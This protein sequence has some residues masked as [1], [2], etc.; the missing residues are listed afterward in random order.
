MVRRGEQLVEAPPPTDVPGL[1]DVVAGTEEPVAGRAPARRNASTRTA[2]AS[3][4]SAPL[5]TRFQP[6]DTAAS[7]RVEKQPHEAS[8]PRTR[9][10]EIAIVKTASMAGLS[11][12]QIAA[13]T[14]GAIAGLSTAHIAAL[15][16]VQAEA[17]TSAL[18]GVLNSA[19]IGAL[20]SADLAT[21]STADI[22]AIGTAA[23]AGL[24]SENIAALTPDQIA[25]VAA[26]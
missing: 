13:L 14:T 26:A 7:A 6:S 18:V 1:E 4:I 21:F 15:S 24:S 25:P 22:A 19:Q 23:L 3:Q 16:T 17:L 20:T 5:R 2:S 9:F 12:D 8:M 10:R 11:A